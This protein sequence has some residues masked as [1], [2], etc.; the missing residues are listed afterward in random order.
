M[1]LDG[2]DELIPLAM[3]IAHPYG[4]RTQSEVLT[5]KRRHLDLETGTLRLDPETAKND[6]GRL[7]YLTLE[8]IELFR[9]KVARL[10]E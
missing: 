9:R 3:T 1:I 4:W 6:E 2:G 8:P 7:F 10:E 5:L